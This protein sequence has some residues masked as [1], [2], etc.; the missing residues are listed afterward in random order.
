MESPEVKVLFLKN[1]RNC[2]KLFTSSK[3]QLHIG[4]CKTKNLMF[5]FSGSDEIVIVIVTVMRKE[6]YR[7]AGS[8]ATTL[9]IRS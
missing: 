3:M 8:G 6:A 2:H 9:K 7:N 4:K 5:W 1:D